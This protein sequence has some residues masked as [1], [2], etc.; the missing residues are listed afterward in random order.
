MEAIQCLEAMPRATITKELCLPAMDF[1]SQYLTA[2][3]QEKRIY[4]VFVASD[5]KAEEH[6]LQ[7]LLGRKV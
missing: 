4:N 5:V 3:A 7:K 1:V 6:G 2:L